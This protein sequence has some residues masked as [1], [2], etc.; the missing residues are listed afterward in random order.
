VGLAETAGSGSVYSLTG[1]VI[2]EVDYGV[3]RFL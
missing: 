2:S 1:I 3:C